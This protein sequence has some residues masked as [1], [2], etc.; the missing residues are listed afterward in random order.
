[1]HIVFITLIDGVP[2]A[3]SDNIT[4]LE[5]FRQKSEPHWMFFFVSIDNRRLSKKKNVKTFFVD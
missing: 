2:K 3:K 4:V 1:M 5:R